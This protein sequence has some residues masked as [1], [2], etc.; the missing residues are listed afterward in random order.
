[1]IRTNEI[2]VSVNSISIS[3]HRCGYHLIS[4]LHYVLS[5]LLRAIEATNSWNTTNLNSNAPMHDAYT[6]L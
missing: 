1:M 3:L 6:E 4:V 5:I 2:K